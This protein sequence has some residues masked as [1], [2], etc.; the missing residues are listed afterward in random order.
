MEFCP[1]CGSRLTPKKTKTENKITISLLCRKRCNYTKI[2]KEKSLIFPV[3]K[4]PEN[5]KKYVAVLTKKEQ[6][7]K[8]LPT[9]KV[10]CPKCGNKKVYVWQVQTRGVDAPSTQ[11][12]RCTKCDYTFREDT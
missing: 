8:T 7:L 10:E 4:N 1:K 2:I 6:K 11:F 12:M 5:P 9:I 3:L